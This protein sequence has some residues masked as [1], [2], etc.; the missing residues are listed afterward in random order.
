MSSAQTMP[1]LIADFNLWNVTLSLEQL[2]NLTCG[3]QGEVVN[4]NSL[5][6]FGGG[7]WTNRTYPCGG[8]MEA[9]STNGCFFKHYKMYSKVTT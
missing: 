7:Q 8:N 9:E 2:Q 4:T 5:K 6:V 3:G 1:G